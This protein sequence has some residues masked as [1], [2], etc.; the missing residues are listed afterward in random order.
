MD[1]PVED[2][3]EEPRPLGSYALLAALFNLLLVG[4]LIAL[5]RSGRE[6][7][8]RIAAPDVL[9]LGAAT[10]KLSRLVTKNKPTSALRAPFTEYEGPAGRG[11]VEE[12]PRGQ[13]LRRAIGELLVCPYCMGLWVAAALT[14]CLVLVPRT[15]RF[16]ASI[17]A[18]LGLSDLFQIAHRLADQSSAPD[19]EH[20][21]R[22][23]G[24]ER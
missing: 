13:G 8:E 3:S 16:L 4:F 7:P 5:R 6:L 20:S 14:C 11:E 21:R 24:V 1:S 23:G 19:A 22:G 17:L 9:L 2:Y 15:T 10:H 18:M 12:K